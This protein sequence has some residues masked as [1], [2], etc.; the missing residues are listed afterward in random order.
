MIMVDIYINLYSISLIK[1][2]LKINKKLKTNEIK[3]LYLLFII[4]IIS[5]MKDT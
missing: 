3:K 5:F 4:N 1:T 2:Q